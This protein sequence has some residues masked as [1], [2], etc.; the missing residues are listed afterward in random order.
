MIPHQQTAKMN[1][2]W[3]LVLV[4]I[5]WHN[6]IESAEMMFYF[7]ILGRTFSIRGDEM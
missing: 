4:D 7:Y 6:F 1:Q 3:M 2:T 5:K